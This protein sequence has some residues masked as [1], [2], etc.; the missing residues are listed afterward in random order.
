MQEEN[1]IELKKNIFLQ[2]E[3]YIL[4]IGE[5]GPYGAHIEDGEIRMVG[6]DPVNDE[7]E[8]IDSREIIDIFKEEFLK[9]FE[10]GI[11]TAAAIG[12]DVALT[13]TS[14]DGSYIKR[15][16]LC[17]CVS[18]DGENWTEDYYPYMIIDG[19]CVWR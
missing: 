1:L 3:R 5:F 13:T 14:S 11:I 16:A 8:L 4:D 10:R 15:D 6:Y 9:R 17:M 18:V 12:Y 2:A 7:K 19:Q